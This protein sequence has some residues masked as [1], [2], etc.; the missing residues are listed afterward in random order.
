MTG[1]CP[2]E[3]PQ[4]VEAQLPQSAPPAEVFPIFP[5]NEESSRAALFDPHF[6][7]TTAA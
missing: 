1:Q 6:G 3:V 2:Q 4:L 7:Q 5:A